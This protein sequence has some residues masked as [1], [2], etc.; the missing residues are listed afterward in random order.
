MRPRKRHGTTRI[1]SLRRMHERAERR[2]EQRRARGLARRVGRR[3]ERLRPWLQ[4]LADVA[5]LLTRLV[6]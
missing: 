1:H 3:A 2:R 5:A 6:R 4:I